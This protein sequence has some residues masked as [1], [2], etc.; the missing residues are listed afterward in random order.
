[1]ES[2]EELKTVNIT[3]LDKELAKLGFKETRNNGQFNSLDGTIN[4]YTDDSHNFIND[5]QITIELC[6]KFHNFKVLGFN[7]FLGYPISLLKKVEKLN[8]KYASPTDER[9]IYQDR[10]EFILMGKNTL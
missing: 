7:H 8:K 10:N 9:C 1:M 2:K 5:V 6:N 3:D 4:I